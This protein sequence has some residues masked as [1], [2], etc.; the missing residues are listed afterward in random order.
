MYYQSTYYISLV[1]TDSTSKYLSH[2]ILNR[3]NIIT[4]FVYPHLISKTASEESYEWPRQGEDQW[5]LSNGGIFRPC[6]S[7]SPPKW[8][9][10]KKKLV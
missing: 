10:M 9:K 3:N 8:Q 5:S 2:H 1:R 7:V 4:L 6:W